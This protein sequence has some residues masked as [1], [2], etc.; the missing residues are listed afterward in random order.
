MSTQKFK[1]I[2]IEK[3]PTKINLSEREARG[4]SGTTL[5]PDGTYLF[6]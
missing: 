6:Q 5:I 4:A 2:P 3:R 1:L